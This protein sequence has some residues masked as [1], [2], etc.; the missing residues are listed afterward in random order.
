M[1]DH[2][3]TVD[4]ETEVILTAFKIGGEGQTARSN[5]IKMHDISCNVQLWL[6][7]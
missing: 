5:W 3:I 4:A 7:R 6:V 2:M 1:P